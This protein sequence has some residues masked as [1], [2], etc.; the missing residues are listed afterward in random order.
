MRAVL[1]AMHLRMPHCWTIDVGLPTIGASRQEIFETE[2][3][4]WLAIVQV[5]GGWDAHAATA[6]RSRIAEASCAP[7]RHS[8]RQVPP[9]S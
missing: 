7:A 6:A 5:T 9:H 1:R 2:K 4:P 3:R 8:E